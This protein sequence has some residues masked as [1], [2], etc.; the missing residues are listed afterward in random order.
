[1]TGGTDPADFH[2]A[3]VGGCS[4]QYFRTAYQVKSREVAQKVM[5]S[6]V[7]V[8]EHFF[9]PCSTSEIPSIKLVRSQEW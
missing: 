6:H 9:M 7:F 2:P 1:M 3:F 8:P 4:G 5:L